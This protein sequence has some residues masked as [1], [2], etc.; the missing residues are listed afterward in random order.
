M[1]DTRDG[2]LDAAVAVVLSEVDD[3][4]ALRQEQ[5]VAVRAFFLLVQD[6]FASHLFETRTAFFTLACHAANTLCL[7]QL[8]HAC[9]SRT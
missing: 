6:V 2:G 8:R 1:A 4:F 3:R 5:K 7:H 9:V